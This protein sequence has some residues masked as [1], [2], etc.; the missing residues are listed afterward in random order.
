M[1]TI[2][3]FEKQLL[4][5]FSAKYNFPLIGIDFI[6]NSQNLVFKYKENKINKY[7]R[8]TS[9]SLRSYNE[10]EAEV[11]WLLFLKT[12]NISVGEP[13]ISNSD[14]YIEE[15]FLNEKT[16]YCVVFKEAIGKPIE[17]I[18]DLLP[19]LYVKWGK[20][21]GELHYLNI[22]FHQEHKTSRFPR[23]DWFNAPH[24]TTDVDKYLHDQDDNI[25]AKNLKLLISDI[26]SLE[27]N[28]SNYGL[29]HSDLHLNNCFNNENK[30][31]FYD[32]D[33]AE[34]GFYSMDIAAIVS[35]F[36][37]SNND[38][39]NINENLSIFWEYFLLGYSYKNHIDK[40]NIEHLDKM[41]LLRDFQTYLHIAKLKSKNVDLN[42]NN[43][44][45]DIK[46]WKENLLNNT[47]R[48]MESYGDILIN[49]S[50][51]LT[52]KTHF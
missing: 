36:I 37:A 33:N 51:K 30:L 18:T 42:D 47:N 24:F 17:V 15:T 43:M 8:I 7:I 10:I 26:S 2:N 9:S 4:K 28:N 40:I 29:I 5:N 19:D 38:L 14:S 21:T 20:F 11:N 44:G 27:Q 50:T 22:E 13:C 49:P 46:T 52:V 23:K 25:I 32:F 39:S 3:K 16:F 31:S 1:F 34:Y 41:L 6:G 45:I 48:I 12:K 35:C